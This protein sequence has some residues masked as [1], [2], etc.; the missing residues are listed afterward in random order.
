MNV[1]KKFHFVFTRFEKE[2]AFGLVFY[3]VDK[4]IS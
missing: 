2:D 1:K 4:F 3:W